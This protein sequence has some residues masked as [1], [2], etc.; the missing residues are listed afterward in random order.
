MRLLSGKEIASLA[1][2]PGS[3]LEIEG[4]ATEQVLPAAYYLRLG[5]TYFRS[6]EGLG[7]AA[8][9][10]GDN[11]FLGFAP[12]EYVRVTTYER[13]RISERFWGILG[14]RSDT[15]LQKFALVAGQFIDPLFPG[16]DE[17]APLEFGLKNHSSD[18]SG[19]RVMDPIAKVCFFDISDSEGIELDDD[20]SRAKGY[21]TQKIATPSAQIKQ[22]PNSGMRQGDD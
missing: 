19:I 11:L 10:I 3:G 13:F 7:E 12:N 4:F 18:R 9:S 5:D 17:P 21:R 20:F 15:A 16:G 8:S 6:S 22:F 2:T 14:G 1:S